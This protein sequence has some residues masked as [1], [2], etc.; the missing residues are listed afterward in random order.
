MEEKE[1]EALME[2]ARK[3]TDRADALIPTIAKAFESGRQMGVVAAVD[4]TTGERKFLLCIVS[5]GFYVPL[6]VVSSLEEIQNCVPLDMQ[7][8]PNEEGIQQNLT[9]TTE[10]L[11]GSV[12]VDVYA[13]PET[14]Q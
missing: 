8:V 13:A 4:R 5:D 9:T 11:S 1:L 12:N 6:T 3:R 2:E 7:G 10:S 14:V